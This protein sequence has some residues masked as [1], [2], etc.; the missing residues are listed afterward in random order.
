M[1]CVDLY[2]ILAKDSLRVKIGSK[3]V[4]KPRVP[5]EIQNQSGL[6]MSPAEFRCKVRLAALP[7]SRNEKRLSVF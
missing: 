7:A 3:D 5:F 6:E 2:T 1:F 4:G